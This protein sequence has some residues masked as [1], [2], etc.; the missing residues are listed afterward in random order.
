MVCVDSIELA[1]FI[2]H[3]YRTEI[4]ILFMGLK[5]QIK[6]LERLNR[7]VECEAD[8]VGDRQAKLF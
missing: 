6:S 4:C 1:N 5:S 7:G 8:G 2:A 3:L